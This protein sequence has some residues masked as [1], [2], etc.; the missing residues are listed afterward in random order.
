[1]TD[2][3]EGGKGNFGGQT[4]HSNGPWAARQTAIG[5][6]VRLASIMEPSGEKTGASASEDGEAEGISFGWVKTRM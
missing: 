1:M 2:R 6:G 5:D 3:G 4:D